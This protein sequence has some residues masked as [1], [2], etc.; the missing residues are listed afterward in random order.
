MERVAAWLAA[1]PG[2]LAVAPRAVSGSLVV[3]VRPGLADERL[4]AASRR[5]LAAALS[6]TSRP[7]DR[8]DRD[9]GSDWHSVGLP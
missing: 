9:D 1:E 7:A 8:P 6:G 5:A 3:R 4:L 2:V